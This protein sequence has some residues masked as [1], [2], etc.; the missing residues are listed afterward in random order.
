MYTTQTNKDNNSIISDEENFHM[1]TTSAIT[2]Q[3]LLERGVHE[4]KTDSK[5]TLAKK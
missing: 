2:H 3:D 4:Y 5:L 1:Y